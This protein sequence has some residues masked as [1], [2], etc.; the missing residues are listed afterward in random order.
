MLAF[1]CVFLKSNSKGKNCCMIQKYKPL[2]CKKY[3]R[4]KKEWMTQKSCGYRFE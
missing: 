1:R 4:T 3:P 2:Q